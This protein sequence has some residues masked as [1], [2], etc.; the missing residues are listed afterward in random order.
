M[1]STPKG[2]RPLWLV[3]T[4]CVAGRCGGDKLPT[5]EEASEL[6]H[7]ASLSWSWFVSSP[8]L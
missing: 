3:S 8:A 6:E 5:E 4:L 7:R 2:V 1:D